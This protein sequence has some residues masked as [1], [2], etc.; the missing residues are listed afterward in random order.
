MEPEQLAGWWSQVHVA[1]S[2]GK[3]KSVFPV[4]MKY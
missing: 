1:L 3:Y 2:S 4:L